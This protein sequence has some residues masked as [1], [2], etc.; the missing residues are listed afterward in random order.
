MIDL[1][2]TNL[3]KDSNIFID[4][5]KENIIGERFYLLYNKLITHYDVGV[6][7]NESYRCPLKLITVEKNERIRSKCY[8]DIANSTSSTPSD[9]S[10]VSL[11]DWAEG[12]PWDT[13]PNQNL[14]W[15][16]GTWDDWVTG[17]DHWWDYT[18][19]APL[20][21]ILSASVFLTLNIEE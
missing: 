15:Y 10:S 1:Y 2:V 4:I 3:R 13:L 17:F 12:R 20:T 9:W 8:T 21:N 6:S 5:W 14:E 18:Y 19:N 7:E 11:E 16:E